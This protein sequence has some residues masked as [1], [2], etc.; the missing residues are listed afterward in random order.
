MSED[1]ANNGRVTFGR[2]YN[3]W[4]MAIDGTWRRSCTLKAVSSHD[5]ELILEGSIEGL[6]LKEFFLLLSSTGLAYRRCELVKVNGA[7]IDIRF[8]NTKGSKKKPS[9]KNESSDMADA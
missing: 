6:N 8:L 3:V 2:G 5:A 4:I 7:Q 9:T 1:V